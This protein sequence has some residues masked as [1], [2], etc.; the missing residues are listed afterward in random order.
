MN[1]SIVGRQAMNLMRGERRER[2][3]NDTSMVSVAR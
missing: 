2:L 3:W 1:N